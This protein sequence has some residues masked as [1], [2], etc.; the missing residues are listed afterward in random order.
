MEKPIL[1][2]IFNRPD[3]TQKVFEAIRQARPPR[4]YIA[5]DGARPAK[6]GEYDIV[7]KTR[8]MVLENIDWDCEV[9]TLFRDKNLGCGKAVSGAITWFFEQEKDGIILEDD[10]LP[11]QSFFTFCEELLDYYSDNK[12]IW[13]ISGD[14]FIPNFDNGASYYFAKVEHCWGWATWA[15][16]WKH[17]DYNL[18]NFDEKYIS[19]FSSNRNVKKYWLKILKEQKIKIGN[20]EFDIWDY[21]WAFEIVKHKSYCINPS[22]NLISNI[23]FGSGSTHTDDEKHRYSNMPIHEIKNIVHPSNIEYDQKAVDYIYENVFGIRMKKPSIKKI[24][25]KNMKRISMLFAVLL[26]LC[27]KILNKRFVVIN[28]RKQVFNPDF[29]GLFVNPFYFSRK[30]LQKNIAYFSKNFSG[31]ILDV[32]CGTK[33]YRKLFNVEKYIGLEYDTP[34]NREHNKD[35][36]CFYDGENFPFENSSFDGVVSFQVL[37]HVRDHQ[38]FMK[39][40]N[41]IL[42]DGGLFLFSAPLVWDEH[43][44]PYDYFRFTSFGIMSLAEKHGFEIVKNIK[45]VNDISIIFQ[46]INDYIFKKTIGKGKRLNKII[47]NL[48]TTP[49]NI[50]GLVLAEILPKN[51]DLYLD[52]VVLMKKIIK[53]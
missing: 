25:K 43:E 46:L 22:V 15:D 40:I 47:V 4:L 7:D 37:E 35:A 20:G 9:K 33:P 31:N 39:E 19:N 53:K 5:S 2:L 24:F 6:D 32:G 41:R 49:F 44:Q 29:R 11:N 16:R 42:K 10:C 36:D 26:A 8:K 51:D 50:M 23:G 34:T 38:G 45:S 30:G 17:F 52:N 12:N 21:Q 14:Q 48:L 3:T 1:F 27:K 28:F 13:H 18:I